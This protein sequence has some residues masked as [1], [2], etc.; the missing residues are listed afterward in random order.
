[1]LK[2]ITVLAGLL[3]I[4]A[5]LICITISVPFRKKFDNIEANDEI[6]MDVCPSITNVRHNEAL[7]KDKL[8]EFLQSY[9]GT[10]LLV[11]RMASKFY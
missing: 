10:D 8:V 1:M 3:L 11:L 9:G 2:I 7:D 5:T 6:L 4:N